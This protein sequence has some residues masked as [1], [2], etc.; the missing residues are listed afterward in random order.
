MGI[1]CAHEA[2]GSTGRWHVD[3]AYIRAVTGAGGVP[4]LIPPA[5]DSKRLEAVLDRVDGLLLPGGID[6]DPYLYGEEPLPGLGK[7]DPEW[8]ALDVAAARAALA[9]GLPVLGIC[10]GAQVL[11][12]AAGGTLYQDIPAQVPHA[13][14]H[15]QNRPGWAAS[16]SVS[17]VPDSLLAGIAGRRRLRV[18]SFHHQAVKDVAAGFRAVAHGADGV[19][20]AIE[21]LVHP[22]ALGV[23]W[24]PERM[25]HEPHHWRLFLS[26]IEA[27]RAWRAARGG[28]EIFGEERVFDAEFSLRDIKEN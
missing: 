6:V 20:E 23:Q 7:V 15:W 3:G 24:H 27:A 1:A 2:S 4:V 11:N 19:V 12:V 5:G 9:R 14:Q 8:D 25:A 22:Y 17:V 18:N 21:S 26:L 16:H 10:R 13:L 28:R